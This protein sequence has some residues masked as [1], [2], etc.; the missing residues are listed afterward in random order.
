MHIS[1]SILM[2][3]SMARVAKSLTEKNPPRGKLTWSPKFFLNGREIYFIASQ[4]KV[5]NAAKR[6]HKLW[7]LGQVLFGL[8]CDFS[9]RSASFDLGSD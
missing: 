8:P 9:S 3:F 1:I 6:L 2:H 7:P 4:R 5:G